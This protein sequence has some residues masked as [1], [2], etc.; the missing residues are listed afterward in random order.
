MVSQGADD[1]VPEPSQGFSS[2]GTQL[3]MRMRDQLNAVILPGTEGA[4]N[5][6]ISPDGRRVAFMDGVSRGVLPRETEGVASTT[7]GCTT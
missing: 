2:F 4:I 6:A 3:M 5:P 7:A 1:R